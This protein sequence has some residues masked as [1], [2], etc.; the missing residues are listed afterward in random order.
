MSVIGEMLKPRPDTSR[1]MGVASAITVSFLVLLGWHDGPA[2]LWP[3]LV[4]LCVCLAQI[5]YPTLLGW[6]LVFVPFVLYAGAVAA[7]TVRSPRR[8]YVL[9][10]ALSLL[11]SVGSYVFRP[12]SRSAREHW[13]LATAVVVALLIVSAIVLPALRE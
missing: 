1:W 8:E 12:R 3:L 6:A 11:P 4:L 7:M 2:G 13:A 5:A 9:F 10:L